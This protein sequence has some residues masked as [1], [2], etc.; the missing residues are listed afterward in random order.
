MKRGGNVRINL[1]PLRVYKD[2]EVTDK[3]VS[4]SD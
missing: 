4:L 2:K 1:R 3:V